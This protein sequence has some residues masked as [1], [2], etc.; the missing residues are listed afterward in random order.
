MEPDCSPVGR[1]R[2]GPIRFF[3]YL[4]HYNLTNSLNDGIMVLA[5]YT[6]GCR[7][8]L[9][10]LPEPRGG[11]VTKKDLWADFA[12]AWDRMMLAKSAVYEEL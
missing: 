12:L 9:L 4:R 2:S 1:H 7:S 11:W 10:N 5:R 3:A 6:M 8:H